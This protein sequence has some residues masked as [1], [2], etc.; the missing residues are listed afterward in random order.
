MLASCSVS[1]SRSKNKTKI[2]DFILI[3]KYLGSLHKKYNTSVDFLV[4]KNKKKWKII[5]ISVINKKLNVSIT[6]KDSFLLL[7]SSLSSLCKTFNTDIQKG[8]D[9]VLVEDSS[10][11][12]DTS[13]YIQKDIGH[14]NKEIFKLDN[15][16]VASKEARE[17]LIVRYCKDDCISLYQILIKFRKLIFDNFSVLIDKYP[18]TPS[19]V[20][21]RT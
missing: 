18:T 1:N 3:F 14:Y 17:T 16:L 7:P 4:Q 2:S 20:R 6:I 19:L 15:L 9:S 12:I 21:Y 11:R 5:S 8:L 10:G 13:F